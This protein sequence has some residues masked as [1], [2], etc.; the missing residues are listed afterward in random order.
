MLQ[1]TCVTNSWQAFP[2]SSAEKLAA[3]KKK[4]RPPSDF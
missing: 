4:I 2:A 3:E 1:K